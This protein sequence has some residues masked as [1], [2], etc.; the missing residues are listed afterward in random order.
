MQPLVTNV[1]RLYQISHV[2][3]EHILLGTR[4]FD[5]NCN[6]ISDRDRNLFSIRAVTACCEHEMVICHF[7][8]RTATL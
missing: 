3:N 7:S 4:H 1:R 8:E 2:N 6:I 5:E